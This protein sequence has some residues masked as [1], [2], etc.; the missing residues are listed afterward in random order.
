VIRKA[1]WT[2]WTKPKMNDK[3]LPWGTDKH[4]LLSWVL[5]F[6]SAK[7]FY[8]QTVLITDDAGADLLI[9][10]L[11]LSFTEVSTCLEDLKEE[12]TRFWMLGKLYSYRMQQ[13]PFVHLDY[14]VYLWKRLPL[15]L[16]QAPVFAQNPEPLIN[17]DTIFDDHIY[18]TGLFKSLVFS[19]NGLIPKEM[20]W[21][22][23]M[24]GFQYAASAGILGGNHISFLHHFAD[25]A[26]SLIQSPSN[27][28]IWEYMYNQYNPTTSITPNLLVEQYFL[29][30]CIEY[31]KGRAES[32]FFDIDLAFLFKSQ[33]D[34]LQPKS[35][36]EHGF[37]HLM[38]SAKANK[39]LLSRLERRV[40]QDYP[41]SYYRCL[42]VVSDALKATPATI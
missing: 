28:P 8:P 7:R 25:S 39:I 13:E 42:E 29:S 40:Q 37:T 27:K 10:K 3:S 16:D 15:R 1:V 22:L 6:E 32:P 41:E 30:A 12:D 5:S 24:E 31:H 2:F 35:A 4:F 34:S 36:Q 38:A 9:N 14:D 26:L 11:K 18:R 20:T 33:E 21:Y 17:G 23:R 19:A